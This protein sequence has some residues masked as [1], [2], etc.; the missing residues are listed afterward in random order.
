MIYVVDASVGVKWFIEEDYSENADKLLEDFVDGRVDLVAPKSFMQEFCN[1]IRK[2][3]VKSLL[4]RNLADKHVEKMA[5]IPIDY[6]D[7]DWDLVKE[8]Y[9]KALELSITVYDAIYVVVADKLKTTIITSDDRLYNQ[10]KDKVRILH[11]RDYRGNSNQ[12]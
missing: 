1:A 7:I 11:I 3:V 6:V 9:A 4:D 8:S 12:K 2:Y 10:L 5:E